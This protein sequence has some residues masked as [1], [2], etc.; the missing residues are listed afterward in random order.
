MLRGNVNALRQLTAISASP[1]WDERWGKTPRIHAMVIVDY[2][3][4][5][6][7]VRKFLII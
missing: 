6:D 3:Q 1:I 4:Q 7:I 2:I 5:V